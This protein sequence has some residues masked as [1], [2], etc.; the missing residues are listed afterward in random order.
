MSTI[1]IGTTFPLHWKIFGENLAYFSWIIILLQVERSSWRGASF[2]KTHCL[3]LFRICSKQGVILSM[4]NYFSYLL[5]LFCSSSFSFQSD[6][7][8]LGLARRGAHFSTR[9][10]SWIATKISLNICRSNPHLSSIHLQFLGFFSQ[11]TFFY[12]H[13]FNPPGHN[14][15]KTLSL[16]P[17]IF[18]SVGSS[19]R[20]ALKL[21][22]QFGNN[23]KSLDLKFHDHWNPFSHST[24]W[25]ILWRKTPS[26]GEMGIFHSANW[27]FLVSLLI[28]S[29][30][31]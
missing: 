17:S 10:F 2:G 27:V 13:Y 5:S 23:S 6:W 25:P 1:V 9:A 3:F 22:T 31:T 11:G 26:L 18:I 8:F 28:I 4:T 15:N 29:S 14:N 21:K 19:L 20:M 12:L 16:K 30:N 24:H 7:F